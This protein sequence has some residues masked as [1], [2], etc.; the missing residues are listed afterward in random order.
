MN[1]FSP[2]YTLYLLFIVVPI[3]FKM[4]TLIDFYV[5]VVTVSVFISFYFM[6]KLSISQFDTFT[7]LNESKNY[8]NKKILVSFIFPVVVFFIYIYL[9]NFNI[10]IFN[11]NFLISDKY[12]SR[13]DAVNIPY[14]S[15]FFKN[16]ITVLMAVSIVLFARRSFILYGISVV[17]IF[18][19]YSASNEKYPLILFIFI[20]IWF[21]YSVGKMSIRF[22]LTFGVMFVA[23]LVYVTR[24]TLGQ[25]IGVDSIS[26]TLLAL[27]DRID[28]ISDLVLFSY[29]QFSD[30]NYLNGATL[31]RFFGLIPLNLSASE[32]V[33]IS[34]Y[35][36]QARTGELGGANASFITEGF[37][38]FGFGFDLIFVVIFLA[39]TFLLLKFSKIILSN[40]YST[41][42]K[43]SYMF[44][45]CDLV[46][47]NMWLIIHGSAV[48]LIFIFLC[49]KLSSV[50]MKFGF[51]DY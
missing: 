5:F 21:F 20:S 30:G 48:V 25:S 34:H 26:E 13:L 50:R 37:I 44:L 31:P 49:D 15:L 42:F 12:Q 22:Y 17:A 9:I 43:L 36:M 16:M 7:F 38:N 23:L 40:Y 24:V 10:S 4:S 33:N 47:T 32:T 11:S 1:L 3:F 2:V 46:N 29:H 14:Y 41:L 27:L 28:V 8:S 51:C 45:V 6:S 19:F 18:L 35:L 39:W